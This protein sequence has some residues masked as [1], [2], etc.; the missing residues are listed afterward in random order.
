[1]RPICSRG[2]RIRAR[3]KMFGLMVLTAF[4]LVPIGARKPQGGC[5]RASWPSSCDG[6]RWARRSPPGHGQARMTQFYRCAC[7]RIMRRSAADGRWAAGSR[8]R[9]G[10]SPDLHPCPCESGLETVPATHRRPR[11]SAGRCATNR[12][13]SWSTVRR[14]PRSWLAAA[15]GCAR[16]AD[17]HRYRHLSEDAVNVLDDQVHRVRAGGR[18]GV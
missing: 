15:I 7:A 5:A 3:C 17:G 16:S 2:P 18:V 11:Q 9:R 12:S 8:A 1:M 10:C 4:V 6:S 13:G 14:A